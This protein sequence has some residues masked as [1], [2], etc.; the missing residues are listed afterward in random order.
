MKEQEYINVSDLARISAILEILRNIVPA[1]SAVIDRNNLTKIFQILVD[2]QERLTDDIY[3][4]PPEVMDKKIMA[5]FAW[6]VTSKKWLCKKDLKTVP[7]NRVVFTVGKIYDEVQRISG[8]VILI[9]DDKEGH[10]IFLELMEN[11]FEEPPE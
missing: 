4:G 9:D 10:G 1:N 7:D 2:W 11:H 3:V 5:G 8:L 6:K